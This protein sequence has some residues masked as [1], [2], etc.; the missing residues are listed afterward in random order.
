MIYGTEEEMEGGKER[1]THG[2][3]FGFICYLRT[4]INVE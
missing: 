2:F 3:M 4:T 1:Y